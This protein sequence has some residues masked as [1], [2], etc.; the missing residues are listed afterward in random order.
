MS[1]NYVGYK[2]LEIIIDANNHNINIS[3]IDGSPMSRLHLTN[4]VWNF[5]ERTN[6]NDTEYIYGIYRTGNTN[7]DGSKTIFFD[8]N[9]G[10]IA[11]MIVAQKCWKGLSKYDKIDDIQLDFEI[12]QK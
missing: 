6:E 4:N 7:K 3:T 9:Y 1:F 10:Y 8:Q 12:Q 5:E 2:S 11:G